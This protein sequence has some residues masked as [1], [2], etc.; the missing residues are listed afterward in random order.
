MTALAHYNLGLVAKAERDESTAAD[1]FRRVQEEA[2]DERLRGLARR[3][4][5]E[6][7]PADSRFWNVY[8]SAA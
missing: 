2:T 3:Q 8:L 7:E 5:G 6:A 4:L 1:W